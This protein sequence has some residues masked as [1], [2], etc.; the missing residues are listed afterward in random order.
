MPLSDAQIDRYSRQII[1]P[2]IGGSGQ[3][4][5]LAVAVARRRRRARSPKWSRSISPA[6][7]SG[8]S[9]LHGGSIATRC[10][11]RSWISIRTSR[12]ASASSAD[13]DLLL[14]CNGTL[15]QIDGAAAS[16]RPVIAGGRWRGSSSR[17]TASIC[18][19]CGARA[20]HR[21]GG[22]RFDIGSRQPRPRRASARSCRSPPSN[23]SS[24]SAT[25][26]GAPGYDSIRRDQH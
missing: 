25:R 19:G 17:S 20:G 2:E 10:A 6:P 11:P 5:L 18:V 14:L 24:A 13:A 22:C 23:F 9:R 3:E 21:V 26:R 15:A 8:G 1:L 7:A 12:L 16:R 4:R